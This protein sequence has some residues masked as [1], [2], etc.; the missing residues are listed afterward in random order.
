LPISTRLLRGRYV[1]VALTLA[2]LV[3]GA[4]ARFSGNPLAGHRIWLIGVVV[5]GAPLVF[6]TIWDAAHGHFAT[7]VVATLSIV[8]AVAL[9]QPLAGL[10]I[11]LMQTTGEALEQYAEGRA[12][13]AVRALEAAAPRTAHV[14]REGA[15]VD[16]PATAV[17]VGDRLLIR[18]GDLVPC[19]G[20]VIRGESELDTSKLTG[21]AAPLRAT[22]ETIV[23]SGMANGFGS[24]E[25]RATALADESQYARI[26]QFVRTA[27]ASKAPLQ[28][29]ADKYAVWFTPI[30]IALVALTVALTGDWLRGLAIMVVAT[31]C[32]LILATP[33]A[34][35]GGINRAA[36]RQVIVRHGGALER[37][38]QIDTAVLDKTGTVTIGQPRLGDVD[39]A[40]GY[41][42]D[43]VLRYAAAVEEHASHSLARVLVDAVREMGL[44]VPPSTE[45]RES[46]GQ[47]IAG[48]VD[49]H[50]VVVGARRFVRA[51]AASAAE[52][53][54]VLSNKNAGMRALV[55]IDGQIAA[56][57]EFADEIRPELSA[58]LARLRAIG[59][60][61]VALYSGDHT[62]I[63]LEVASRLGIPDAR[64]DLL[65]ADKAFL[66]K[67]LRDAGNVVMMIGDGINDAPALTAADVGVALAS[68][69]GGITAE[70]ADVIVLA[71]TLDRIADAIAIARRT[72]HVARQSIWA[73]LG[74]SGVLMIVAAFG[75]IPP[76]VGA[77]LQELVDVAVIVNALRA[78]T[79][80]VG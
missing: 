30:T 27:Q 23:M 12:S 56:V 18:P 62:P 76:V 44:D 71:D 25:M 15:A 22:A 41:D 58:T 78:S 48:T 36:R 31:P 70:A 2:A 80:H 73:G 21:E 77:A 1:A 38:S 34:I 46:P 52:L 72:M 63:A 6:R 67:T 47:G 10:V 20:V 14:L 42:R 24:F 37:L 17:A 64:G 32:P 28:R 29:L 5:L 45:H 13:A 54:Q 55:A 61:R 69:G 16:V 4:V 66:V 43:T 39:V 74:I 75:G 8:G 11:V 68:Q 65:P 59:V 79:G 3:A 57:I 9:Q 35:I 40:P 49:G 19:D 50:S 7:D 26:V 51:A 60:D 33:V 53:E